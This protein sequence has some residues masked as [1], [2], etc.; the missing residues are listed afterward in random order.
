MFKGQFTQIRNSLKTHM[1]LCGS[2]LHITQYWHVPGNRKD[3]N[4]TFAKMLLVNADLFVNCWLTQIRVD[5]K[6][7]QFWKR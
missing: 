1:Y 2:A 5:A 7:K 4:G 3:Q 6:T